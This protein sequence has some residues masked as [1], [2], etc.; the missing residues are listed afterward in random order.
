MEFDILMFFDNKPYELSLYEVIAETICGK[1][2]DVKTKV[3]KTQI[4]FSN[5]YNFAFVSLPIRNRQKRPKD[6]VILTFGLGREVVQP[7]IEMSVE[8]Y[9]NRWTHHVIVQN[10][11]EID[12]Q[13]ME[14]IDEAYHF[15]LNK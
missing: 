12:E 9:P 7:R 1:Y 15:S 14:W 13:I 11:N 5:K 8:P 10:A 4:S 3:S 6:C 2:D